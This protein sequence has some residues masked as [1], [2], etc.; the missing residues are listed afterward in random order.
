MFNSLLDISNS[1]IYITNIMS[2]FQVEIEGAKFRVPATLSGNLVTCDRTSY[3]YEA[4]EGMLNASLSVLWD[5]N[6]VVDR[7]IITLYKCGLVGSYKG[8]ADCSL[9]MTRTVDLGKLLLYIN[10]ACLSVCLFVC[11]S[12]CLFV[13]NKRQ[14]G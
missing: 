14:N 12:V 9:C 6:H 10:L 5:A 7:T 2:N 1:L 13:S 11:L 4:A 3:K 8:H